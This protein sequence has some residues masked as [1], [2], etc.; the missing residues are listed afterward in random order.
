MVF[1][2]VDPYLQAGLRH[3]VGVVLVEFVELRGH[4]PQRRVFRAD[5]REDTEIARPVARAQ[6]PV[7]H[8]L[9]DPLLVGVLRMPDPGLARHRHVPVEVLRAQGKDVPRGRRAH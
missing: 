4:V 9:P 1:A 2:V 8:Q 3:E 5:R 7:G 6:H